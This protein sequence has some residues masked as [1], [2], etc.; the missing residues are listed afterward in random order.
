MT[1]NDLDSGR[2]VCLVGVAPAE[3]M[4][5]IVVQIAREPDASLRI[6]TR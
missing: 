4:E 1:T 5:Y 3:P 6:E 2:L